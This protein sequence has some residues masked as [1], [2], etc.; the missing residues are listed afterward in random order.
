[1]RPNPGGL[2]SPDLINKSTKRILPVDRKYNLL[3]TDLEFGN[4]KVPALIDTGSTNCL[5]STDLYN[6]IVANRSLIKKEEKVSFNAITASS[7]IMSA[8]KRV[9]VHFKIKPFSWTFEFY[10][11]D[12]LP[13]KVI[14]GLDFMK[15]SKMTIN[16]FNGQF[17]FDFDQRFL[18]PIEIQAQD[19]DQVNSVKINSNLPTEEFDKFHT[20][21]HDFSDVITTR[22]GKTHLAEYDIELTDFTPVSSRPYEYVPPKMDILRE[23]IDK[24]LRNDV[25]EESC[26]NYS[27]P[28]LLVGK[29]DGG[30]RLVC[31][32]RDL[33]KKIKLD[34]T[35]TAT[36]EEAFQYLGKAKYY[37]VIDVNASYHQLPLKQSC[38]YLTAFI[39]KFGLFQW[40]RCPMGMSTSGKKLSQLM[41]LI[42]G[43]I[44]Y[45]FFFS[46]ADDLVV[47]SNSLSE[48]YEHLKEVLSRLRRAGLTVKPAKMSVAQQQ[49]EFLGHIFKNQQICINPERVA[50]IAG[51]PR[52]KNV[53]Q[54]SR[55]L[56][57][58]AYY[59]RYIPNFS[60]LASPLNALKKKNTPFKW[61]SQQEQAFIQLKKILC[62]GPVLRMPDFSS[63]FFLTTDACLNGVAAVLS[64][65][66]D[67][68]QAPVAFASRPTTD[69]EKRTST[70]ELEA[71]AVMFGLDK[72]RQYLE[73]REFTIFCDNS[74][75]T[76]ILKHPA[77]AG[78][79]AR[80][81]EQLNAF[82]FTIFHIPGSDNVIADSLSRLFNPEE[83]ADQNISSD[84]PTSQTSPR[85]NI[86]FN[87]PE[88]FS[89]I[90][91][92]QQSDP[93][94]KTLF[95]NIRQGKQ[96]DPHY[97]ISKNTLLYKSLNQERSR[98]VVPRIL[99]PAILKYYHEL[100]S[101]LHEGVKR[102]K[103]R[104]KRYFFWTTLE[105][106]VTQFVK[107]C[108]ACQISKQ[109]RNT[110]VGYLSSEDASQ[111]MERVHMDYVGPLPRSK[112]GNRYIL[113]IID[114]FSK[115]VMLIPT[116]NYTSETTIRHFQNRYLSLFG[117]PKILVTD[118]HSIFKSEKFRS[119]CMDFGIK[120]VTTAPYHPGPNH[121]ER[122]NRQL[123]L[124]LRIFH[125]QNHTDWD[126]KLH[127]F[128][129][130]FNTALHGSTNQT[131]ALLFLGRNIHQPLE[132]TWDLNNLLG[133]SPLSHQDLQV[134]WDNAIRQLKVAKK[135]VAR[136]YNKD[137]IPNYFQVGDL[138]MYRR[139]N[140]SN[141]ADKINHKLLP[142]W[143][144][145][146]RIESFTSPVT[147]RLIHPETQNFVRT[148]HLTQLKPYIVRGPWPG[149]GT[150]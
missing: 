79:V 81:L 5:M 23:E 112:N 119:M 131:P 87:I 12:N 45:K 21:I 148:A 124:A 147:V 113:M 126:S 135:K 39:T 122:Q 83:I 93:Q 123:K 121:S 76:W 111:A 108:H 15:F 7:E 146:C 50:P 46:Y 54:L 16:T 48:H 20:L 3:I 75:V 11:V 59:A 67:G 134:A 141:A 35:P 144:E 4:I 36:V 22:L 97:S 66:V 136:Q 40:K 30:F 114:S 106:D 95:E 149:G 34:Q 74:A 29:S 115:F 19:S 138:V 116:R 49:I 139:I 58:L 63:R 38:R 32:Y 91:E 94:L 51:Y 132:L 56:G 129:Q 10:V 31:D 102:T 88:A 43:D 100:P 72:F 140:I 1:M 117:S 17:S 110:K 78:K 47:Y 9:S 82:K 53:K 55:F 107:T 57:L 60:A 13:F 127:Y 84:T 109:A 99:I 103:D 137:R 28:C 90:V 150:P 118:N 8:T 105:K 71:A 14:V 145:P 130:A 42:F 65:E 33:N 52:P 26:S 24:L 133:I 86:L 101:S 6:E 68:H 41:N 2:G 143:S 89:S 64:Q 73:H 142:K 104:I 70:F 61:T 77:K 120:H 92:H 80:W 62:S 125:H 128:T 44:R 69:H 27:S 98:V 18:F 85:I 25:I 37:S 96:T